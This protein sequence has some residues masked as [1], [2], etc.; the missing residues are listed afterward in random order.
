MLL[1]IVWQW[2][3]WVYSKP[4]SR[5]CLNTRLAFLLYLSVE[6]P[7]PNLGEWDIK[8]KGNI[9][10]LHSANVGS[11]YST[12]RCHCLFQR[13]YSHFLS[14][15]S[16]FKSPTPW[17]AFP[18][19]KGSVTRKDTWTL[20]LANKLSRDACESTGHVGPLPERGPFRSRTCP[21]QSL[22][23]SVTTIVAQSHTSLSLTCTLSTHSILTWPLLVDRRYR[24]PS[25]GGLWRKRPLQQASASSENVNCNNQVLESLPHFY[26]KICHLETIWLTSQELDENQLKVLHS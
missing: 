9:C 2:T 1:D 6:T 13:F 23:L 24:R 17:Q 26:N 4:P 12:K 7:D 15:V 16:D 11:I 19:T 20:M 8:G 18:N 21:L 14:G 22:L 25:S 3:V 5:V 10:R